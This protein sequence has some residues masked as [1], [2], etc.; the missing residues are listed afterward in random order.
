MGIDM[1]SRLMQTIPVFKPL[2]P[3]FDL[4]SP[5]LR[6]IDRN[7][8][9][10]NLGPLTCQFEK[11]L[12][13]H[14][15]KN[16]TNIVTSA[17]GTLALIQML[18]AYDVKPGTYCVLPSWT[19]VATAAA[20]VQAGL[21]P[22]FVD[23]D[24]DNWAIRPDDILALLK[25]YAISAVIPVVPFGCPF[26]L[27]EWEQFNLQ[28]KI[29][30]IIDAAAAFD[31]YSVSNRQNTA[32][33]L[34]FMVSLHATK[35]FG[36]GEGAV[37]VTSDLSLSHR[38]KMLGNFGFYDSRE[39]CLPGINAKLNEYASAIGLAS[40]DTW[41][42]QRKEWV[43]LKKKFAHHVKSSSILAGTPG[44]NSEWVSSYGQVILPEGIEAT[45]VQGRLTEK[46]IASIQWWGNGCH[47]HTAYKKYPRNALPVTEKLAKKTLGLPF[48]RGLDDKTLS[49][50]F[51]TLENI[52]LNAMEKSHV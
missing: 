45:Y 23:V 11:C 27:K 52:L 22:Y 18:R 51:A 21:I 33:H 10:T 24:P 8:Y 17:N 9:Y 3:T 32:S 43:D 40:F 39:A 42:I 50:I 38:I 2:L 34:P 36:I 14:F 20:V 19:F 29:P 1:S 16:T 31:S 30:V 25:K 46:G 37:I 5:Y 6:K 48:W 13:D 15:G 4:L 49:Q 28:T 41:D 7:R 44:F 47:T 26:N 12:G 35:V